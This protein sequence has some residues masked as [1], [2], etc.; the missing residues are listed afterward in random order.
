[1]LAY[2]YA[3]QCLNSPAVCALCVPSVLVFLQ[4]LGE[5]ELDYGPDALAF[6]LADSPV[7]IATCNVRPRS[8]SS[9]F[10]AIKPG[11]LVVNVTVNATTVLPVG[12]CGW[13]LKEAS[14]LSFPNYGSLDFGDVIP[15]V[16]QCVT[17][18]QG[19]GVKVIIGL[20]HAGF[21]A[22]TAVASAVSGVQRGAGGG[23]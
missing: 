8:T 4:T 14:Y 21:A 20:G 1:M 23:E 3:H 9:L 17:T 19:Q 2:P 11:P 15:S 6:L 7:P 18:L 13:T 22:D 10:N 5:H 12:I 16:Q